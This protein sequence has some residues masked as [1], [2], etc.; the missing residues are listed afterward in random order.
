MAKK[1]ITPAAVLSYPHLDEPQAPMNGQG[2]PKYSG[3]LVFLQGT[4]LSA[5]QAAVLEA[6]TDKW[7]ASAAAKL[8]SGAL[9]SPF[10]TDAEAKGYPEGAIFINVRSEQKPGTVYLYPDATTG[11]PAIV[12][13]DKVKETFYAGATVRAS[14][15]AF[16]Y[17]RPESKGVSFGLNNIQLLDGTTPRLDGRK[18]AVDEFEADASMKPANIDDVE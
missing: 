10:R 4:D 11:K 17:D 15:T 13:D 2:N 12:P 3:S 7:G 14:I 5:L 6:A 1:L 16:A 18:A 8:K 9:K